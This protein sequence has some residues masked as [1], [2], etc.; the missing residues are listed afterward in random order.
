MVVTK[1][2]ASA[3]GACALAAGA[4]LGSADVASAG[5]V[6]IVVT[7][8]SAPNG[9]GS[10]SYNGWVSNAI[11]A[12]ENGYSSY[13]TPGTPEYYTKAPAQMSLKDNIVTGFSSWKG[14]AEPGGSFASELGNRLLFGLHIVGDGVQQ[15][16]ISQLSFVMDST[17]ADNSLDFTF[18]QGAYAYSNQY[19]GINW[20]AD[21]VKGGGDDFVV[22]SGANTQ[23]VDEIVGRGSGNAWAVYDTDP[24]AT[25]Q[26]KID[27]AV[28]SI[29]QTPFDFIGTYKLD[30][31]SSA[32]MGSGSVQFNAVPLPAAAWGGMALIGAV[33]AVRKVRS[34]RQAM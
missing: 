22:T 1:R 11:T 20:G 2:F 34:R 30:L 14:V 27:L 28:A 29:Q 26:E 15:F 32:V 33:G 21:R 9:F 5:S 19:V 8:N 16:S 31:G 6:Q 10:P 4:L 23:L 17:D 24:G 13:G 18:A 7:P 25:R 12:L 3:V